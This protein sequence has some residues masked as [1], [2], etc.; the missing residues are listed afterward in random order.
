MEKLL[1]VDD[2]DLNLQLFKLN[3]RSDYQVIT[4]CNPTDA[5]VYLNDSDIKVV[6]TDYKMPQMNGMQFVEKVKVV[7]PDMVCIML[8]GYLESEVVTDKSKL[9]SYIMKPYRKTEVLEV[10]SRAFACHPQIKSFV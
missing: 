6:V 2:E 3:F 7:R 4:V 5:L 9:F 10:L 8:S 1:Y